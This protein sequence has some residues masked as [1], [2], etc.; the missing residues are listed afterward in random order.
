[1]PIAFDCKVNTCVRVKGQLRHFH[2]DVAVRQRYGPID[3]DDDLLIDL[4]A[5]TIINLNGR[6]N[7]DVLTRSKEID[8]TVLN[9]VVPIDLAGI[10]IAYFG[11]WQ[12]CILECGDLSRG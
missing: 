1:M 11:H 7:F 6:R 2:D 12:E 4:A 8:S 5:A 9:R 3:S 10:G